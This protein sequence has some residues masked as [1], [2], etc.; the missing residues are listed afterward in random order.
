MYKLL[1]ASSTHQQSWGCLGWKPAFLSEF[2]MQL[3]EK[4]QQQLGRLNPK[5][6]QQILSH[7]P[8]RQG[9]AIDQYFAL[10]QQ[11]SQS[12]QQQ[13]QQQQHQ[14]RQQQP[15]QLSVALQQQSAPQHAAARQPGTHQHLPL[16]VLGS[17]STPADCVATLCLPRMIWI[18]VAAH[19]QAD[20]QYSTTRL[21]TTHSSHA[22]CSTGHV[23]ALHYLAPLHTSR[24]SITSMMCS[25]THC[26]T[27]IRP[28]S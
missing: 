25:W 27:A 1:A 18:P 16:Q 22:A 14:Q 7:P 19:S 24:V 3:S 12:Q 11:R 13:Q 23:Q 26:Q 8:E 15:Q 2:G 4:H 17:Q 21:L 9:T 10:L 20:K 6:Q 5:A 28:S